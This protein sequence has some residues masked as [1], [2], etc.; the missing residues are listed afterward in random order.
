MANQAC[1][2]VYQQLSLPGV[3]AR[4]IYHSAVTAYI[5]MFRLGDSVKRSRAGRTG[6]T[7]DQFWLI[8]GEIYRRGFL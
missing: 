1:R 6:L 5:V 4:A 7:R 8:G 3:C 2:L